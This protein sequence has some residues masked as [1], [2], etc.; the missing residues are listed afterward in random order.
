MPSTAAERFGRPPPTTPRFHRFRR[1]YAAPHIAMHELLREH[2]DFICVRGYIDVYVV[3]HPDYVRL[4]LA[5]SHE[6]FSKRTYDY[7]LL[8]GV[9]GNGLVTND[10]PHWVKQRRLMQP[11]FASRSVSGFDETINSLT[12]SLMDQWDERAGGEVIRLDREMARLTFRIVG[13]TLFGTDIERHADEIAR[14]LEVVNLRSQ[15][16][17]AL[18]TLHSWVPTPY[19][20]KWKRARRRLD[21]IVYGMLAARRRDGV[22]GAAGGDILDRLISSRDPETGEGMDEKQMR[23]EVVTLML[24]GHETSANALTW[25]L[26]LLAAHPEVEARLG[27]ELAAHL[28]GVPAAAAD[29]ARLPYLRQVV[30]ESMR[31]YPPVWGYS[32][33]SE[34]EE[35]FGGCVLPADAYVAVMPWALHRHPDFWPDA[36]RF[37]PDR[38]DPK[39]SEG[40]HSYCY[41][42]FGAG[43]RTCIGAGFAMFEIQLV[44]AQILQRFR[45]RVVPGHPVETV[46]KTTLKPRYGMPVTLERR[47]ARN[48]RPR[49][50][51]SSRCPSTRARNPSPASAPT[52]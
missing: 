1:M 40:R 41:L 44:L 18:M 24:A 22:G 13:A 28:N 6:H 32:R 15:E 27:E 7:R 39:R 11:M 4:V 8:A 29:L 30:Q 43:P 17:R 23:D 34:H 16:L 3:N 19:N 37:D 20:L 12:S 46:A 36:E 49:A 50:E 42:P 10:G 33:R 45:V 2:G 35:E 26:F 21:D 9:M 5:R 14:I 51:P 48:I 31:I 38:F 25:T 52:T 47:Q